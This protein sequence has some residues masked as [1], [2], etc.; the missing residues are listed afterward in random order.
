[1]VQPALGS[2]VNDL[3]DTMQ[4]LLG[5]NLFSLARHLVQLLPTSGPLM[6]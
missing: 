5:V 3:E 4:V 6:L 1:M 2:S